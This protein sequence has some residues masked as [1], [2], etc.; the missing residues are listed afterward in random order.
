MPPQERSTY[1]RFPINK[2]LRERARARL[3]QHLGSFSGLITDG[4]LVEL[5]PADCPVDV[6][7]HLID[8]RPEPLNESET[9]SG[10]SIHMSTIN[11]G[12]FVGAMYKW[13]PTQGWTI[14]GVSISGNLNDFPKP[15]TTSLHP[16]EGVVQENTGTLLAS[17]FPYA[18]NY[19]L[20]GYSHSICEFSAAGQRTDFGQP[21]LSGT[22][23]PAMIAET[24]HQRVLTL[25]AQQ[26]QLDPRIPRPAVADP[27][28]W[29][30]PTQLG[31]GLN[32][33]TRTLGLSCKTEPAT[34]LISV[35]QNDLKWA[36]SI[37]Q[38]LE[39]T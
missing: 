13:K 14:S 30:L 3:P 28:N 8:V 2:F 27:Q 25:H 26:V 38:K 10:I 36:V 21:R 34:G 20:Q 32:Q 24:G 15:E 18:P 31:F 11:D 22:F 35:Y 1:P 33:Y 17:V 16:G 9:P 19:P 4:H 5:D 6:K 39:T 23:T 12:R 29:E 37:P 7:L